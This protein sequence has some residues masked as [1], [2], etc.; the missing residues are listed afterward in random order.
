[1]ARI[2]FIAVYRDTLEQI[3]N[4]QAS[5]S[6]ARA[7]ATTSNRVLGTLKEPRPVVVRSFISDEARVDISIELLQAKFPQ[8]GITYGYIGNVDVSGKHDDR[9][10]MIFTTA[11]AD[12]ACDRYDWMRI[13]LDGPKFDVVEV[14]LKLEAMAE[15]IRKAA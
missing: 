13:Y 4:P 1:M 7:I 10:W 12:D 8:L 15:R 5:V 3:G 6:A 11:Q 9:Q 14:A 2:Q